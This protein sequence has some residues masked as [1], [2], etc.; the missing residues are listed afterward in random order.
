MNIYIY[1]HTFYICICIHPWVTAFCSLIPPHRKLKSDRKALPLLADRFSTG[2]MF[3]WDVLNQERMK[4]MMMMMTTMMMMMIIMMM[5]IMMND[6]KWW[7]MMMND[8]EW[9]WM[10]MNDDEWWWWWLW[11][12]WLWRR[13]Q[14]KQTAHFASG[15]GVFTSLVQVAT[16]SNTYRTSMAR[17]WRPNNTT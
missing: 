15:L 17:R 16:T 6:D 11:R 3:S 14:I 10:M 7:W 13:W 2:Q 1:I 12:Q 9:W 4:W 5:M 8:D